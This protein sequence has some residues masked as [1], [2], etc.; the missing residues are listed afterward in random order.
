MDI[1][2]KSEK[3]GLENCLGCVILLLLW[4]REVINEDLY[5]RIYSYM[6]EINGDSTF[7]PDC[8]TF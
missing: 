7:Y 4:L 5:I 3:G 6:M 8:V 2:T 1:I